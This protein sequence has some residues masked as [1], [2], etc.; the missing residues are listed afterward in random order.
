[1]EPGNQVEETF[2]LCEDGK[3]VP[4]RGH[5]VPSLVFIIHFLFRNYTLSN[6][7]VYISL[8]FLPV[9]DRCGAYYRS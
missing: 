9:I 6:A 2:T 7:T 5:A 1:M 8:C 3:T 4:P